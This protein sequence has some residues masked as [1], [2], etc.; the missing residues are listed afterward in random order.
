MYRSLGVL[1]SPPSDGLPDLELNLATPLSSVPGQDNS[2][3]N[4]AAILRGD[5]ALNNGNFT[6]ESL[7]LS[8]DVA[9]YGLTDKPLNAQGYINWL[10]GMKTAFPNL[11]LEN[12]PYFRPVIGQGDWTATV[13]FLSG[14]HQGNLSLPLYIS[15]APVKPTGENFSLLH[16]TIARWKEGKIV[17]M[18]VNLDLFGILASLNI[19]L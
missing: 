14:T 13:A 10:Q 1:P 17:G 3:I 18:R 15:D 11:R 8:P 9:V 7:N 12:D 19:T 2:A 16:F 4:K 5:D 6:L